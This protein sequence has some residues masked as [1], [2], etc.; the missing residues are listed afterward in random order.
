MIITFYSFFVLF[1]IIVN[2]I[3]SLISYFIKGHS[4]QETISNEF[5]PG[6]KGGLATMNRSS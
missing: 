1:R 6:K 4:N 3:E 5:V 2:E